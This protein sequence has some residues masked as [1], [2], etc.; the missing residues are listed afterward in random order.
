MK[1]PILI[2]VT[3]KY[4]MCNL[5]QKENPYDRVLGASTA[6]AICVLNGANII[7]THNVMATRDA[8][9]IATKL[10]K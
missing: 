3:N 1:D 4:L 9:T 10:S 5:L 6:E 8:I 2:A 7:R